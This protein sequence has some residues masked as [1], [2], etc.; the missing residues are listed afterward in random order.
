[1]GITPA[2]GRRA[3]RTNPYHRETLRW[4]ARRAVEYFDDLGLIEGP[5]RSFWRRSGL[6]G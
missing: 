5:G 4:A 3:A 1:V 6:L 2:A